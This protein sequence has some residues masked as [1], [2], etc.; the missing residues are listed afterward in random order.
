MYQLT[1]AGLCYKNK[2]ACNFSGLISCSY[3]IWVVSW[4]YL[5]P[6]FFMEVSGRPAPT[7]DVPQQQ[8]GGID[9]SPLDGSS[10]SLSVAHVISS[11]RSL[12]RASCPAKAAVPVLGL[13]LGQ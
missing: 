11:P 3:C 4:L 10:V 2:K 8:R 12:N 13:Y 1:F 5:Q 6:V 7:W 9:G